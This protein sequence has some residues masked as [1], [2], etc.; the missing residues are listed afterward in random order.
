MTLQPNFL[1]LPESKLPQILHRSKKR[2]EKECWVKPGYDWHGGAAELIQYNGH[3]TIIAGP[4]E[5]GKTLAALYKLHEILWHKPNV[6]ALMIRQ[7][8][9]DLIYSAVVTFENKILPYPSDHP[10]CPIV[11]YGGKSPSWYDYPNGSRLVLAG[12]D[13]PGKVLSSEYDMIYVNQVEELLL[14]TWETL[15]GRVTG[16]AGHLD[17]P[18]IFGDCNPSYPEHWIKKRKQIKLI[19]S[20]HEDNPVL[21]DPVTGDITE[22]GMRTMAVL[23]GLTGLRY[24][25]GRLGLWVLAEGAVFDNFDEEFNVSVN[26]EYNP[27]LPVRWGVDDGYVYGDGPGNAN[28]HP[29]VFLLGQQTSQGGLNIFYEYVQAGELSEVSVDNVLAL[30]YQRPELAMVDSSAAELRRRIGD[31]GIMH[32]GATHQ[33]SEGIKVV[34]RYICDG[35]GV[36]LLQIHPRCVN[37]ITELQS[38]RYDPKLRSV[39]AGEA[40]P[41]K[42]DDHCCDALR[43]MIWGIK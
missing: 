2:K 40:A 36:R 21:F 39:K 22:Q 34:R 12:M 37:L 31:H 18:Q 33:V 1:D 19:K 3:E 15:A 30:P 17:N 38:Y 4:F 5:T 25:R 41:L 6:Q 11:A 13:R 24:K 20:H 9:N 16:R 28:Y 8:Y 14:S 27:D 7:I 10:N 29:R 43:Y 42:V 32:S 23:D 26:A 35:Q